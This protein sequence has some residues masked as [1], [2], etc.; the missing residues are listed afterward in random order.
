[1]SFHQRCDVTVAGAAEQIAFPMTGNGT[2]LNL[3]RLSRME[4]A[5]TI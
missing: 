4:M 3:C 2:I 1:M 5:S